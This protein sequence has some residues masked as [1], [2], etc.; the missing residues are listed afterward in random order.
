GTWSLYAVDDSTLDSGTIANGWSLTFS[1]STLVTSSAD[2]AVTMVDSPH[3]ATVSNLLTYTITITNYGP[4]TATNV[5]SSYT[6]PAGV[7]YRTNIDLRTGEVCDS[8]PT[9]TNSSGVVVTLRHG[10]FPKDTGVALQLVVLPNGI[11]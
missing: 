1:T 10:D 4:G 8:N 5:I 9:I 2:L 7:T 11:G 6:L 3:P